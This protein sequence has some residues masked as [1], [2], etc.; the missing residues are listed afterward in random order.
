M[1]VLPYGQMSL[2]GNE[3]LFMQGLVL[4]LPKPDK[5]FMSKF[6]GVVDG[7][8]Y[9]E[10]GP[11]KQYNKSSKL[12]VKSTIRAR[13]VIRL[14][15]RDSA[16]LTN[17]ST[18]L[19]VG[20]ISSL[21]SKNQ[22]RLIFSK[23]DLITVIIPLIKTYN[24]QFLTFNRIKQFAFLNYILDNKI[25]HWDNVKFIPSLVNLSEEDILNLPFFTYWL[26]GFTVAEGSFGVKNNGSA[27]YSIKQKGIEKDNIIKAICKSIT[28]KEA[29]PIKADTADCFQLTFSSKL[30]LQ[31]VK[32]KVKKKVIDFF[33]LPD[34]SL[35]G[36]KLLQYNL[37]IQALKS[38]KRYKEMKF[39]D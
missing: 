24:L 32:K 9:I 25:V 23:K 30:D 14:H 33:S 3:I 7:D 16:L 19:G 34:N 6:I 17:F 38:S 21:V 28:G 27:F 26:T 12:S 8:G 10:I 1:Y 35:F 29:R 13:L 11:Q 5:I 36:Y 20:S 31:K 4:S 39:H 37:W 15:N 2:W 18:V 22:T